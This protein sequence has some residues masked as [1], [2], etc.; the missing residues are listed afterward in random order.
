MPS[1]ETVA[2]QDFLIE[3][4]HP[5]GTNIFATVTKWTWCV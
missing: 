4:L 5:A 2:P 3:A 1:P